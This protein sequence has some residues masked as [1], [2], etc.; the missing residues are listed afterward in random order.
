LFLTGTAADSDGQPGA[1]GFMRAGHI[2]RSEVGR[3]WRY[4]Q[5]N[6]RGN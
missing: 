6:D 1:G 2:L 4:V 5:C 3:W